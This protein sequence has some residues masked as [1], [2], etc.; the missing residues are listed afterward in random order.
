MDK[1]QN[2]HSLLHSRN[3]HAPSLGIEKYDQTTSQI[4]WLLLPISLTPAPYPSF[5]AETIRQQCLI[6]SYITSHLVLQLHA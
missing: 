2:E 6:I 4:H 1:N 5:L 3:K